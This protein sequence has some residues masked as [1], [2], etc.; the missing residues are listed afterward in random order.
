MHTA[1]SSGAPIPNVITGGGPVRWG[2]ATVALR[3]R[4]GTAGRVLTVTLNSRVRAFHY[5]AFVAAPAY[6]VENVYRNSAPA[7]GTSTGLAAVG[8]ALFS[9]AFVWLTLLLG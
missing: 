5:A 7:R 4:Q 8:A 3:D 1:A 6:D 2:E 9:W